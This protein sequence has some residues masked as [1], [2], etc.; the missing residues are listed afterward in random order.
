[1]TASAIARLPAVRGRLT[2]NAPVGRQTWLGAG[3]QAEMLFQPAD[4]EDLARFLAALPS[5]VPLTV[6]GGGANVLVRDGGI[7]G[8][9]IRLGRSFAG[10]AVEPEAVCAGAAALDLGVARAAARA[11]RGALEFLSGIPGTIGGGLRMNAGAYGSEIED[12]LIS[13]VALDRSGRS[14]VIDRVAMRLSYRHCG[15]DADWIFLAARLRAV[16][17]DPAAIAE[18]MAAIR[19]ARAASQPVRSRTGG[20]TFANPPGEAAWRLVDMAGCR[21]LRRG[22]AMVSRQ[23]ANFLI[24]TGN[25]T[26]ADLEGLGEEVRRRVFATSGILLEWEIRRIGRPLSGADVREWQA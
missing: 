14:H 10:I 25:A 9:T 19:A 24:N 12:V 11:R 20:S 7:P 18:R 22:G 1:V 26:A 5:E 16:A 8:V 3:G 23:H 13:A 21:G 4:R 15:V 2:P 17:G 6:L